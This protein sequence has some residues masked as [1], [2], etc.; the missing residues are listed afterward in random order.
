MFFLFVARPTTAATNSNSHTLDLEELD[1]DDDLPAFRSAGTFGTP[2]GSRA[3]MLSQQREI[4]M[5]KRQS[6]I[7][8]SGL[9]PSYCG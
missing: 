8:S 9:I 6:S 3:R 7:Q 2:S 5:K 1:Q 4:L